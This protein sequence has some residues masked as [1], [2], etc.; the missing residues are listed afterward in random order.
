VHK[1]SKA[2][3]AL[4]LWTRWCVSLVES[5]VHSVSGVGSVLPVPAVAKQGKISQKSAYY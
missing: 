2:Y 5:V 3:S 4:E 1:F